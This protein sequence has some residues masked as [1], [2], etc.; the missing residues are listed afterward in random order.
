MRMAKGTE[1][2]WE[3]NKDKSCR[4]KFSDFLPIYMKVGA[5]LTAPAKQAIAV[6][7]INT[8]GLNYNTKL[9]Y[10]DMDIPLVLLERVLVKSKMQEYNGFSDIEKTYLKTLKLQRDK[11]TGVSD[12]EL[13]KAYW[14]GYP[15]NK[16]LVGCPGIK[17]VLKPFHGQE[18]EKESEENEGWQEE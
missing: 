6:I 11:F 18:Y 17:I 14:W 13:Q 12:I 10:V 8:I 9:M 15:M 4:V 1:E 7:L 16:K 2:S 5:S 3:S